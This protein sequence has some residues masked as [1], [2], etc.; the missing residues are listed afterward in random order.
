VVRPLLRAST[1]GA[2]F[3]PGPATPGSLYSL[4]GLSISTQLPNVTKPDRANTLPLPTKLCNTEVIFRDADGMEWN[5]RILYCDDSQINYQV[6]VDIALGYAT[7]HIVADDVPS[8]EIEVLIVP[9]DLGIFIE[10]P[11]DRIGA[12]TFAIGPRTGQKMNRQNPTAPC[13]FLS[14]FV[15]GVGDVAGGLPP[16]GTPAGEARP[17][18]A[19]VRV[20]ILN[21]VRDVLGQPTGEVQQI[22]FNTQNGRLLYAGTQPQ[23]VGLYQINVQWPLPSS[24]LILFE[25]DYPM[26]IELNGQKRDPITIPLKNDASISVCAP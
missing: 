16:D 8:N 24:N 12:V 21:E 23:F 19:A 20:F 15:T 25:G 9:A 5:A 6:P 18:L 17:A 22:E 2:N 7:V 10:E 11:E 13:D 1:N 3:L 4:F 26:F 14:I